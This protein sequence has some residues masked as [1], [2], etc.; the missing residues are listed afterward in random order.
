AGAARQDGAVPC[1][2]AG[3]MASNPTDAVVRAISV[4]PSIRV[5]DGPDATS[6]T[7]ACEEKNEPDVADR[8]CPRPPEFHVNRTL[9]RRRR[10]R[11]GAALP[12]YA[13]SERARHR[14]RPLPGRAA[15]LRSA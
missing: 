10:R 9:P 14:G 12:A 8:P 7:L 15:P 11:R 13:P 6:E 3:L 4:Q 5:P 1:A 2:P